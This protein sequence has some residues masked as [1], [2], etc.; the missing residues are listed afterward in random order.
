MTQDLSWVADL[1]NGYRTIIVNGSAVPQRNTVA[2]VAATGLT[3]SSS[4]DETNNKTTVTFT[5]SVPAPVTPGGWVTALGCDFTQQG[6]VTVSANGGV[7]L[8]NLTGSAAAAAS[9]ANAWTRVNAANDSTAMTLTSAGL[10]VHPGFGTQFYNGGYKLCGLTIP[11]TTLIPSLSLSTQIRVTIYVSSIVGTNS[12]P[13]GIVGIANGSAECFVYTG[14]YAT[15]SGTSGG[16]YGWQISS[17]TGE[18]GIQDTALS[19]E[20]VFQVE[21]TRGIG[22]MAATYQASVWASGIPAASTF[23]GS[24]ATQPQLYSASTAWSAYVGAPSSWELLVGATNWLSNGVD[25]VTIAYLLVE[26]KN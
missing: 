24:F 18:G 17:G 9:V 11:L 13:E 2:L 8:P 25:A 23:L 12:G 7:T 6:T 4:D 22:S 16:Y 21:L 14:R 1:L 10:V 3:L 20:N 5:P 19:T 26:Y 15:G